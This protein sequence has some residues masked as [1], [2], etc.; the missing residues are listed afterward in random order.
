MTV[1]TE[2]TAWNDA[3]AERGLAEAS[4]GDRTSKS[5]MIILKLCQPNDTQPCKADQDVKFS[6]DVQVKPFIHSLFIHSLSITAYPLQGCDGLEP[7]LADIG[8]G[9]GTPRTSH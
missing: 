4:G 2:D 9:W 3:K 1:T 5:A 8:R 7:I 6:P